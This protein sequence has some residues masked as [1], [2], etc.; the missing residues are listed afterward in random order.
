MSEATRWVDSVVDRYASKCKVEIP[1]RSAQSSSFSLGAQN[2]TGTIDSAALRSV[3]SKMKR[4]VQNQMETMRHYLCDDNET[5]TTKRLALMTKSKIELL[6]QAHD[7][8]PPVDPHTNLHEIFENEY[9]FDHA[10]RIAP[11]FKSNTVRTYSS[12][13]NWAVQD[14]LELYYMFANYGVNK[15]TGEIDPKSTTSALKF[16]ASDPFVS[17]LNMRLTNKYV[18]CDCFKRIRLRLE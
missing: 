11:K 7:L 17:E 2:G 4:L 8:F 9:G 12:C 6:N 18:V 15:R 1:R 3:E 10:K 14:A 16:F 5:K 13:W